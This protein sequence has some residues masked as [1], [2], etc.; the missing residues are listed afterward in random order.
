MQLEVITPEK[1][2]FDGEVELVRFPG[3]DG[4]FAVLKNHAPIISTL[5][6]GEI[7]V[8][9]VDGEEIFIQVYGGVVEVKD[10]HIIV[11]IESI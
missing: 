10:N 8:I 11:L 7:K 5:Q 1:K 3:S 2:V 6:T 4:S 9:K